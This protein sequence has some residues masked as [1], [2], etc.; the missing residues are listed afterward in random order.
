VAMSAIPEVHIQRQRTVRQRPASTIDD[1][2]RRRAYEAVRR[3]TAADV[4]SEPDD[5][6][7]PG[8]AFS[9]WSAT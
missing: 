7:V 3:A 1:A 9:A 2:V 4:G 8:A 6:A 5:R